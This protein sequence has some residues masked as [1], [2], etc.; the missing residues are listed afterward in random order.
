MEQRLRARTGN[1][2]A[3]ILP[4]V[5][6]E[7]PARRTEC[8]HGRKPF[9]FSES[10]ISSYDS[11]RVAGRLPST[12]DETSASTSH[13]SGSP[14]ESFD[15][16]VRDN[17]EHAR[18]VAYAENNPVKAGLCKRPEDWKWSSACERARAT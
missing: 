11:F 7:R 5:E 4:A 14:K 6:P 13:L 15:Y 2:A 16:K 17:A 9:K 3:G 18:L 1:V 12:A 10:Q 8:W